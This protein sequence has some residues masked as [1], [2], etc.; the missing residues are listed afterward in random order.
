M[1]LLAAT[2][3]RFPRD[4]HLITLFPLFHG[5]SPQDPGIFFQGAVGIEIHGAHVGS[6][7][8]FK[9]GFAQKE[10]LRT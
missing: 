1:A 7:G 2:D 9:C 3:V 4:L 8:G 6:S 5:G 10:V